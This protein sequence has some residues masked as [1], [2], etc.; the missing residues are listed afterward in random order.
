[1][2]SKPLIGLTA[3]VRT[4]ET[5]IGPA[6]LH[7]VSRFYIEAVEAAGGIPLIVP[8]TDAEA[9]SSVA[10]VL[11]GLI[12][13]GGE[14]VEPALYGRDRHP[15][16]QVP[17]PRRDALEIALIG[18]ADRRDLPMFCICRGIQVLNV[19]RHGTLLQHLPDDIDGEPDHARQDAYFEL[20][21]EVS[22]DPDS[23]LSRI[24]GG[25]SRL[26]VNSAHHQ[27]VEKVGEGLRAVAWAPEGFV[28]ALE[29]E[30]GDRF[31]V[32]VQWHPEALAEAHPEQLA[33]FRALVSEAARSRT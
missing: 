12:V 18:E 1:M 21:H 13:T 17:D 22:V 33:P 25:A 27:A 24:F 9:A 16:C 23:R 14:D 3:W 15:K 10:E 28:E 30:N 31:V 6:P 11:D 8:V 32:G 20:V 29:E 5:S 7:S 19:A 2:S 4:F 26:D